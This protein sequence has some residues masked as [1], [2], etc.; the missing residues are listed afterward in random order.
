M[1]SLPLIAALLA[2]WPCQAAGEGAEPRY[3]GKPL[4]YWLAARPGGK[5]RQT[6]LEAI[7]AIAAFGPEAPG[8]VPALVGMLQDRDP[9]FHAAAASALAKLGPAAKSA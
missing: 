2:A 9:K 4:T 5:N 8:A 3:A 6:Q 7:D 1:A